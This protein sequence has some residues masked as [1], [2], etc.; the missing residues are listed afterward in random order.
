M[1][2]ELLAAINEALQ[3]QRRTLLRQV[4]GNEAD[5]E[6]MSDDREPELHVQEERI[7]TVL[8]H[9]DDR[10]QERL[11]EIDAMEMIVVDG[12]VDRIRF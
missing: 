6:K 9:L 5:F 4:S 2:K 12:Q 7:A 3:K 10:E 11:G 1:N 8:R